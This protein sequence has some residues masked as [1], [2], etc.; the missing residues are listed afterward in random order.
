M[1]EAGKRIA[2][3]AGKNKMEVDGTM[4]NGS[5]GCF[6]GKPVNG[7]FT[8][9]EL[10]VV[11]AIIAILAAM[12]LPALSQAR[13]RGR[14]TRCSSN[15]SQ[16]MKGNQFYAN[17]FS[18]Y[19]IG[20]TQTQDVIYQKHEIHLQFVNE[21]GIREKVFRCSSDSDYFDN[22]SIFSGRKAT[23][24]AWGRVQWKSVSGSMKRSGLVRKVT[25]EKQPSKYYLIADYQSP[26]YGGQIHRGGINVAFLDGH[27]KYH[28]IGLYEDWRKKEY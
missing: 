11:I 8:L 1:V 9:I 14:R 23:S 17:A 26:S 16:M 4:K 22:G 20:Y 13:E 24:Y 7:Y 19:C 18:D 25:Q 10:L 15:L 21:C 3:S 12:L 5:T 2:R 28:G 6:S 27:V